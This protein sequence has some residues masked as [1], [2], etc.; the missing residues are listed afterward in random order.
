MYITNQCVWE[1][2]WSITLC[3][4]WQ[5]HG[6]VPEIAVCWLATVLTYHGLHKTAT[7]LQMTFSNRFCSML[8]YYF[9]SLVKLLGFILGVQ[10]MT[11]HRWFRHWLGAEHMSQWRLKNYNVIWRH[12][13]H[14]G[15]TGQIGRQF[16][17]TLDSWNWLYILPKRATCEV[18]SMSLWVMMTSSNWSIFGVNGTFRSPVDYL[19]K[20]Q[21]RRALMFS[22]IRASTN[23]WANTR[24]VGDLRRHRAHYGVTVM[25]K[26]TTRIRQNIVR[27]FAMA[28]GPL[29]GNILPLRFKLLEFVPIRQITSF[30]PRKI[31]Q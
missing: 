29:R 19:H 31:R 18:S 10:L 11:R 20:G 21:W 6:S 26:V 30:A 8:W 17:Q 7:I 22:L 15:L 25:V 13:G 5:R 9:A 24:D 14:H 2:Y 27:M 23:S 3:H 28:A 1:G 16:G 4:V 12:L